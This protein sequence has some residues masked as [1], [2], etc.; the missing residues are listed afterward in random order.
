MRSRWARAGS[1]MEGEGSFSDAL[2]AYSRALERASLARVTAI[3]L[4]TQVT[5]PGLAGIVLLG[6]RPSLQGAVGIGL[7]VVAAEMVT[8]RSGL[9]YMIA[10]DNEKALD[11]Y[12]KAAPL[13][14]R[15]HSAW[16][17]AASPMKW[18]EPT[19]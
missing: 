7:V 12:N 14:T 18:T 2:V 4:V 17:T 5:V 3:L 1:I 16:S 8:L 15:S 11:A 13:A 6:E 9:G 10:G 19:T